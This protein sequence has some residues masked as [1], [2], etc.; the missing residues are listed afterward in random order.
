MLEKMVECL[1]LKQE[2]SLDYEN[3]KQK[4]ASLSFL[5]ATD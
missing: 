3:K 1:K 4:D 5:R 2:K